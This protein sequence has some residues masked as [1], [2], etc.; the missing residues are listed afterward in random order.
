MKILFL[1]NLFPYPLDNGGKIKTYSTLKALKEMNSEIDLVCFSED[2]ARDSESR[3]KIE[4]ICEH[5]TLV[6]HKLSTKENIK[7]MM[8]VALK[9]IASRY[10]YII[11]KYK[12]KKMRRVVK[13]K[14]EKTDYD[15]VYFDH[16]QMFIYFDMLYRYI[17]NSQIIVDQHNCESQIIARTLDRTS[18]T[19][20]KI[21]LQFEYKKIAEYERKALSLAEKVFVLSQQDLDQMKRLGAVLNDV[22]ILPIAVIDSGIIK[23]DGMEQSKEI[24]LLFIG[25]LTWNPNDEGICWF[26]ENVVPLLEGSGISYKLYI[27]GKNPSARLR[28]LCENN[29]KLIV[30]GYAQDINQ[31]YSRADVMVVPLFIG[32]GQRVKIIEAFSKGIPV[33]ST[34]IGAEGLECRNGESILIADNADEFVNSIRLITNEEYS[35]SLAANSRELY[36]K[37]YS[38]KSYCTKYQREIKSILE[39]T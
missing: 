20:K 31:Y 30:T 15:I 27:V 7:E 8:Y 11:L 1:T 3:K 22:S 23:R 25:T 26:V 14:L 32:G 39:D 4:E 33:I 28:G 9:S 21:F 6:Q 17:R 24:T 10:P 2:I 34:T 29:P 13:E 19:A 35:K 12:N 5:V 18:N 38:L 16:L 36:E 37:E